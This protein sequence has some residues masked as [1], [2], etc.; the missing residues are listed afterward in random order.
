MAAL[1]EVPVSIPS[2]HMERSVILTPDL[3]GS[4]ALFW[5]TWASSMHVVQTYRK[6]G[7]ALVAH[8]FASQSLLTV[9]TPHGKA[10]KTNVNNTQ[11]H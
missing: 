10:Q 2:I 3:E 4:V 9:P 7:Q 8:T 5:P 1:V 11:S 6:H